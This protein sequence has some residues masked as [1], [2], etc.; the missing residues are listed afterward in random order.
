MDKQYENYVQNLEH[1]IEELTAEAENPIGLAHQLIELLL[2]CMA[3]LKSY[4]MENG[5]KNIDEEIYFFKHIKPVFLF[6]LVK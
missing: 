2:G 4:V 6:N 5:F 1:K 3:E